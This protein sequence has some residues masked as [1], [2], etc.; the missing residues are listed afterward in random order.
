MLSRFL[1]YQRRRWSYALNMLPSFPFNYAADMPKANTITHGKRSI[2]SADLG[3]FFTH[4]K[5][6]LR[7][8]ARCMDSFSKVWL[9]SFFPLVSGMFV[10]RQIFQ[11]G[12]TIIPLVCVLVVY[13]VARRTCTDEGLGNERV[14]GFFSVP[15]VLAQIDAIVSGALVWSQ[16]A[17]SACSL[18]SFHSSKIRHAVD[19][20]VSNN[21]AP[22]FRGE[23]FYC[24]FL[25]SHCENLRIRFELWSGSSDCF[26]SPAGR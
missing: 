20:F 16:N 11:I 3:A 22:L 26:R 17:F 18:D 5:H 6:V 12:E 24:K 13:L 15:V 2:G 25:N 10:L 1:T 9:L 21:I 7:G 4:G 14:N 23:F 19:T 8:K